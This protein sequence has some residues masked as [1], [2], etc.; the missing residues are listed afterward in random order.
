M[1]ING[2]TGAASQT[3]QQAAADSAS[4]AETFDNFLLLLTTQLQNQDPLSPMDTNEFTQQLVAF[5]EV[6]Q[7]IKTND[8]LE[9]MIDL[10]LGNQ[11]T[12]A[13]SYIGRSV[14][15]ESEF[16]SLDGGQATLTYALSATAARTT[17]QIQDESGL[18]VRTLGGETEPGLHRLDWDGTDDGGSPLPDGVYRAM[19]TAVDGDD[20]PLSVAQGTLGRVTGVEILDGQV[21]LSLNGLKIPIDKVVSVT[22]SA[23]GNQS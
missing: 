23:A 4:L 14:E 2:A 8:R 10:Q 22:E 16:L 15:A 12:S 17:I 1:E 18:V 6:E 7:S 20:A 5:T 3:G 21:V 19:V 9:Q 13:A 11:L